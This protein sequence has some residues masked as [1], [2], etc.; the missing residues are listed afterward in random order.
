MAAL[1]ATKVT[2]R[3]PVGNRAM[4]TFQVTTTAA[5]AAEWVPTGFSWIDA[6]V[7]GGVIGATPHTDVGASADPVSPNYVLNAQGTGAA[8]GPSAGDLGIETPTA[9]TVQITVI[10][11]P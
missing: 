3:L 8:S 7:E 6:V 1:T 10:G 11:I 5:A 2:E 9:K 4:Q